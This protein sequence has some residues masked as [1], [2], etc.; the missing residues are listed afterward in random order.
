MMSSKDFK[1]Y[2]FGRESAE[3]GRGFISLCK[4]ILFSTTQRPNNLYFASHIGLKS[5][6]ISQATVPLFY[7][8][9]P[10]SASHTQTEG[11]G[12][13]FVLSINELPGTVRL[14]LSWD[15]CVASVFP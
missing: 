4:C 15:G 7:T 1:I 11:F 6:K 8:E 5:N 14:Q 2:Y 9:T 10:V 3:I 12:A 13:T